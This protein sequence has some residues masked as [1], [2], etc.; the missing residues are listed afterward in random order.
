MFCENGIRQF[1]GSSGIHGLYWYSELAGE[2]FCRQSR[3]RVLRGVDCSEGRI[4]KHPDE[5]FRPC[6][7]LRRQYWIILRHDRLFSMTDQQDRCNF[8][9]T[10]KR[11]IKKQRLK[12][13]QNKKSLGHGFSYL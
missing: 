10:K 2:R 8:I 4:F 7:T 3:S 5:E 13:E 12:D 11:T 9:L 1:S 6:R